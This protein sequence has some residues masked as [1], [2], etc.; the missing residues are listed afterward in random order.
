M[1]LFPSPPESCI[2]SV[3]KIKIGASNENKKILEKLSPQEISYQKADI[4]TWSIQ[5]LD[6]KVGIL[7]M[8]A[9]MHR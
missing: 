5:E 3:C 8:Y 1:V 2:S 6:G 7:R 4:S 9:E